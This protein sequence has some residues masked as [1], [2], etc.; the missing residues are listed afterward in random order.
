MMVVIDDGGD[1]CG[2][3]DVDGSDDNRWRDGDGEQ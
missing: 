1:S 3:D 2:D